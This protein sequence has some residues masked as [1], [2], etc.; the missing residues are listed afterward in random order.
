MGRKTQNTTQILKCRLRISKRS[1][2]RLLN[3][4]NEVTKWGSISEKG[5]YRYFPKCGF[6][7][8]IFVSIVGKERKLK[9]SFFFK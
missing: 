2:M 5:F 7:Q 3:L 4:V 6:G 1:P 8:D 9:W